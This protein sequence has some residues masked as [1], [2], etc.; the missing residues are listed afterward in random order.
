MPFRRSYRNRRRP[1]GRKRRSYRRRTYRRPM[2]AYRVK[3]IINAELK[4]NVQSLDLEI[5][6]TVGSIVP[7]TS[8]IAIGDMQTQRTGNWINPQNYHGNLVVKGNLAA[9]T[10]G[11]DS[12][13]LRAGVFQWMNDEQFDPPDLNQIVHDPLAPLGPLSL[14]NKGSFKQVWGRTFVIMND[15]DNSQFIKKFPIYVRLGRRPKSLYD[16]DNPKKFQ[17]FFFIHSDSI[18]VDNPF[19]SLD[20]VLRYTDS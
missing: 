13:L 8:G 17:Y 20:S 4:Y 10:A 11:T 9:M 16:A 12:F 6:I 15:D 14:L 3:R 2:T 19:F 5:P 1:M 7:L 18:V